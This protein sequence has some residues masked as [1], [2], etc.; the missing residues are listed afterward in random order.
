MATFGIEGLPSIGNF[1][2]GL[3]IR[4]IW[5]GWEV[6]GCLVVLEIVYTTMLFVTDGIGI[7]W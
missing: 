6:C 2:E 3:F 4:L 7:L 5:E 1:A